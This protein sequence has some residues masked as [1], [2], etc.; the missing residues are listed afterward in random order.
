M[1]GGSVVD[2]AQICFAGDCLPVETTGEEAV[3]Y[4]VYATVACL[5]L[6]GCAG[7]SDPPHSN[8]E[9]G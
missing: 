4:R 2:L 8:S 1:F 7:G 6:F 3:L 5:G 9:V